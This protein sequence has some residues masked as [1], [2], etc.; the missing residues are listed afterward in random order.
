MKR[1]IYRILPGK[2]GWNL[3]IN[4]KPSGH[5]GEKLFAVYVGKILARH[6]HEKNHINTQVVIHK[7]NGQI[8]IE[9]TYGDDP[10]KYKG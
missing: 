10:V 3:E 2:Q 5:F 9:Y 4:G 7:R 8:Q 6:M 1:R